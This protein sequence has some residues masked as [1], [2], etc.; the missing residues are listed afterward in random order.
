MIKAVS[1]LSGH[2]TSAAFQLIHVFFFNL[3]YSILH[4]N[5]RRHNANTNLLIHA[6]ETTQS[7]SVYMNSNVYSAILLKDKIEKCN[8][9]TGPVNS[10]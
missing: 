3:H 10:T 1:T 5:I 6:N 4:S 9:K 2:Y 7:V 8:R